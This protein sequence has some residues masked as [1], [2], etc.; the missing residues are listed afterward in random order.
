MDIRNIREN[1]PDMPED[2]RTR[3]HKE[4]QEHI[5]ESEKRPKWRSFIRGNVAAVVAV[6]L[7]AGTG[8]AAAGAKLYQM[9]LQHKNK[10]ETETII[11]HNVGENEENATDSDD[12][13]QGKYLA[14][15]V[16]YCPEGMY[17]YCGLDKVVMGYSESVNWG[18]GDVSMIFH[19]LPDNAEFKV[20]DQ[21]V[22]ESEEM[23]IAGHQAIL[24]HYNETDVWADVANYKLYVLYE[25]GIFMEAC[26][27]E[28][29]DL[30]EFLRIVEGLTLRVTDDADEE[31]IV[32]DYDMLAHA[33]PSEQMSPE[34]IQAAK[35]MDA[36]TAKEHMDA[37]T[38]AQMENLHNIGEAFPITNFN[39]YCVDV[40]VRDVQVC[41]DYSLL[42]SEIVSRFDM[43]KYLDENGKL[44]PNRRNYIKS[45]D[46]MESVDEIVK[47]E[48]INEKL[49]VVTVDYIN[50][51]DK[52]IE[53]MCT[54]AVI[55]RF[56]KNSN[57]YQVYSAEDH[58]D[59]GE[60][61][62]I[63]NGVYSGYV[64]SDYYYNGVSFEEKNHITGLEPGETM[65]MVW[66]FF[67]DEDELPY[68]FLSLTDESIAG[69]R[70]D[71]SIYE[72]EDGYVD[73]RQYQR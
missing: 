39:H 25:Q 5:E 3:I 1:F 64:N 9:S 65:T 29:A 2:I 18:I 38:D 45:G 33:I 36:K 37:V 22:V 63:A 31:N 61:D 32:I 46:G 41:D 34:E 52:Y 10:Y 20:S 51:G 16:A 14:M 73:I 28:N 60:W 71:F 47:T 19:Q 17:V 4:V 35:E 69:Q 6:C 70:G 49:I 23:T 42:D 68:L 50:V 15:D 27:Y 13:L 58:A 24:I 40:K 67:V 72:L 53:D 30:D 55:K 21:S 62:Y 26:I 8:V 43:D 7:L 44:V 66:G 59:D 56:E 54:S 48:E 11:S 57:G 12:G